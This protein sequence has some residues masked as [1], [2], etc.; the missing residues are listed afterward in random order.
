MPNK[1]RRSETKEAKN[2]APTQPRPAQDLGSLGGEGAEELV[3]LLEGLEATVTV[4]G[5]G[6]D[7]LDV[8]GLEVRSLGGGHNTL[9]QSDGA[10]ARASHASLDHEPVLVHLSVVREATYGGDALLGQVHLGGAAAVI[11]FLANTKDS[12]VDLG[13]VVVTLLTSAGDSKAHA[14][15]VPGSDTGD[16]TETSVGLSGQSGDTPTA[17]H[18]LGSVTAGGRADVEHLSLGEDRV[19]IHLLLKQALGEVNLLGHL[20]TVDLHLQE[21]SDLLSELEL[22]DLGVGEHT[23]DLAV[24]LDAVELVL[25]VLGFLGEL[26]G[27]LGESLSLGSVPVLVESALHLVRQ[28]ASPHGG[29]GA[30]SGRGLD[31]SHNTHHSHG[32]S[33]EDGH[34]LHSVLL[35]ELGARSLDL[36]NNVSHAGL[37]SHEGSQV[38]R[39]GLIGILGEGTDATVV[40]LGSLLGKVLKRSVTGLFELTVRHF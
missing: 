22:A 34:S 28:V 26:L 30:E 1:G 15:R 11:S 35:V 29:E 20:A 36:T 21:V 4:L 2:R 6:V 9:A 33:L 24:V 18:T 25:D 17:D 13:T 39:G 14:G 8:E 16:L 37:V 27:V 7:E 23:N 12:L 3:L 10:L 19:H 32:G 31:I 40:V 38:H 5:R